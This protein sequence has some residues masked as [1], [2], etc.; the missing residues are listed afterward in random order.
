M[1]PYETWIRL[2]SGDTPTTNNPLTVVV[3]VRLGPKRSMLIRR[4]GM[5][6]IRHTDWNGFGFKT[7]SAEESLKRGIVRIS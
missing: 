1:N 6:F 3:W 4:D 7:S 2:A 5:L